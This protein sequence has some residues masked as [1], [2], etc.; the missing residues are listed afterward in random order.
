MCPFFYLISILKSSLRKE[1]DGLINLQGIDEFE[2]KIISNLDDVF[3]CQHKFYSKLRGFQWS[4]CN[5][6]VLNS[7]S[8]KRHFFIYL[9]GKF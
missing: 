8:Y 2:T 9:L 1:I 6:S 4:N 7:N 5:Q 3:Q